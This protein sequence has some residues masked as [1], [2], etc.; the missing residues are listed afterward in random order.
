MR[1]QN[2]KAGK[3]NLFLSSGLW[4]FR[5]SILGASLT[6]TFLIQMWDSNVEIKTPKTDDNVRDPSDHRVASLLVCSDGAENVM[7]SQFLFSF[8]KCWCW[9]KSPSTSN[10]GPL[11]VYIVPAFVPVALRP[12]YDAWGLQSVLQNTKSFNADVSNLWLCL[13]LQSLRRPLERIDYV[14]KEFSSMV[15][16]S[17][18]CIG[19]RRGGR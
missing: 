18:H 11:L 13:V 7:N 5:R 15:D 1:F 19:G 14:W 17:A 2:I 12:D 10:W 9:I 3:G 8:H 4:P 16:T 6:W